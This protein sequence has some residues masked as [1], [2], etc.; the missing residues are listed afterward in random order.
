MVRSGRS[1]GLTPTACA[2]ACAGLVSALVVA[3]ARGIA[4]GLRKLRRDR[5]GAGIGLSCEITKWRMARGDRTYLRAPR[6]YQFLKSTVKETGGQRIYSVH[7]AQVTF[8]FGRRRRGS[9]IRV[10]ASSCEQG[11]Q[12]AGHEG[13]VL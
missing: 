4:E 13:V 5:A 2:A 8:I 10:P 11:Y 1:P 7:V 12:A 9:H 6:R 3:A